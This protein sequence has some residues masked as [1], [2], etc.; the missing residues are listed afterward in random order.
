M[1]DVWHWHTPLMFRKE[2]YSSLVVQHLGC[3]K[4]LEKVVTVTSALLLVGEGVVAFTVRTGSP[5]WSTV[6]VGSSWF[7]NQAHCLQR[8]EPALHTV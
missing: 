8:R 7:P 1:L 4:D 2:E 6:V 5:S 3:S